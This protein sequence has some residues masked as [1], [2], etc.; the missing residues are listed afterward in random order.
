[1]YVNDIQSGACKPNEEPVI[2]KETVST[3][4]VDAKSVLGATS[5]HFAMDLAIKKARQTGIGWVAVKGACTYIEGS[6]KYL[7][8]P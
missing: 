8:E 2:L 4:W 6:R 7:V 1:M 5:G 3:A